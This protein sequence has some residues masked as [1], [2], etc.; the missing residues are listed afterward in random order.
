MQTGQKQG[1]HTLRA[2]VLLAQQ[3]TLRQGFKSKSFIW[4]VITN[5][6]GQGGQRDWKTEA[7]RIL[8]AS[9]GNSRGLSA[10]LEPGSREL[11]QKVG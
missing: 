1:L 2:G 8:P 10:P 4:G 5:N 11:G 6:T 7:M 9:S 3:P